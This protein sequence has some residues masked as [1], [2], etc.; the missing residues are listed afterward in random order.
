MFYGRFVENSMS[1]TSEDENSVDFSTY[2][3][4]S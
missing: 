1:K 3:V 4:Y 2:Y